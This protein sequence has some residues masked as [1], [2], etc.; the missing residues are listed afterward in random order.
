MPFTSTAFIGSHL[1][2]PSVFYDSTM[3]INKLNNNAGKIL[4]LSGPEELKTWLTNL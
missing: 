1:N 2:K 4:I 3:K